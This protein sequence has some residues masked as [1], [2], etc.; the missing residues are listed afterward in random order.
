MCLLK[1]ACVAAT[2]T[3]LGVKEK[4]LWFRFHIAK[5]LGS[6]GRK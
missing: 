4:Y 3:S 2:V 6:V 1:I 5:K